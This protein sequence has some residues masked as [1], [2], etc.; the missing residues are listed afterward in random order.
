MRR[1]ARYSLEEHRR[2]LPLPVDAPVDVPAPVELPVPRLPGVVVLDPLPVD[3]LP[4]EEP[5]PIVPVPVLLEVPPA[6]L[7]LRPRSRR[8][9][10]LSRPMR[11][12]QFCVAVPDAPD[13]AV[14]EPL[15]IVLEPP[16]VLPALPPPGVPPTLL[17]E[18]PPTL[19]P[20]PSDP[21]LLPPDVC[22]VADIAKSAATAAVTRI[23]R[24]MSCSL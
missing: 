2:Y 20:L 16:T 13:P 23:L 5:E 19:L 11:R 12:S 3:P 1:P 21:L 14:L 17:P 10:S 6:P 9:R 7:V 4:M 8:Q 22:A 18:V 15:P 24:D